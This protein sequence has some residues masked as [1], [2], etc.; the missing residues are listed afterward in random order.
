MSVWREYMLENNVWGDEWTIQYIFTL[1]DSVGWF[2]HKPLPSSHPVY[3]EIIYGKKPWLSASTTEKLPARIGEIK[4]LTIIIDYET[5][6]DKYSWYN[7]MIDVWITETQNAHHKHITDEV[8]IVIEGNKP[9]CG[10]GEVIEIDGRYY[11]YNARRGAW[12]MHTFILCDGEGKVEKIDVMK[13][14]KHA[15]IYPG[16]YVA[17]IE[18]GN[19]IWMGSGITIIKNINVMCEVENT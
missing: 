9:K 5:L 10:A 15:K 13:F 3:P 18:F 2:W 6:V 11:V 12:R 1:N 16:Y 19:E 8:M 7:A 4:N 17:S 14:I